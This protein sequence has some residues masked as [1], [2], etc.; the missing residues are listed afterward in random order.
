VFAIYFCVVLKIWADNVPSRARC[1]QY[2]V[3]R[4]KKNATLASKSSHNTKTSKDLNN[5]DTKSACLDQATTSAASP[6]LDSRRSSLVDDFTPKIP[7]CSDANDFTS[8]T[9]IATTRSTTASLFGQEATVPACDPTLY[10]YTEIPWVPLFASQETQAKDMDMTSDEFFRFTELNPGIKSPS[11]LKFKCTDCVVGFPNEST[12]KDISFE[13]PREDGTNDSYSTYIAEVTQNPSTQMKIMEEILDSYG[14]LPNQDKLFS[15]SDWVT[16]LDQGRF[17][18]ICNM[19]SN[20]LT[21]D[22]KIPL[23]LRCRLS[24]NKCLQHLRILE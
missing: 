8:F 14:P 24:C 3:S 10:G 21:T 1:L 9:S 7:E 23:P 5:S 6:T 13:L 4:W 2:H 20:K 12:C 22:Q 19:D 16:S 11:L 17:P 15:D 18:N